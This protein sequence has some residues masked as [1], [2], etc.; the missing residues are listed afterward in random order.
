MFLILDVFTDTDFTEDEKSSSSYYQIVQLMNE[1]K[2]EDL[3]E[4]TQNHIREGVQGACVP[5]LRFGPKHT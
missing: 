3:I 1:N 2:Y 5:P 4:N